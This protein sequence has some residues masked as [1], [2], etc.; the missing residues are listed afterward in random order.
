VANL[1]QSVVLFT[2]RGSPPNAAVS[3]P[4]LV[5]A[6]TVHMRRRRRPALRRDQ[7][8]QLVAAAPGARIE[9]VVELVPTQL[10]R[11]GHAL[12]PPRDG[13]G[14]PARRCAR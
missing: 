1:L 13:R 9:R 6:N 8:A 14:H 5:L 12:G 4:R 7:K 10:T 3:K 11:R 2:K